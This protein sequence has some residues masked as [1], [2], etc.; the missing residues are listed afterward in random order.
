MWDQRLK[1]YLVANGVAVLQ[2]NPYIE[3]NW[4]NFASQWA[5]GKDQAYLPQFFKAI[6]SG[7]YGARLCTM[8]STPTLPLGFDNTTPLPAHPRLFCRYQHE[9]SSPG[10]TEAIALLTS[11][12]LLLLEI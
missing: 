11:S 6:Q 10:R 2:L 7:T 9:R 1:Q 3:D 8:D 5:T 12:I 4:D